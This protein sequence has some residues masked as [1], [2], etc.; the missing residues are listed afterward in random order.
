MGN[1]N[2]QTWN[3]KNAIA[4]LEEQD[5]VVLSSSEFTRFNNDW[6]KLQETIAN[7][8]NLTNNLPAETRGFS[9]ISNFFTKFTTIFDRWDN[10]FTTNGGEVFEG[11]ATHT[12]S[13][14][15]STGSRSFAGASSR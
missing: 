8:Q 10:W 12:S 7:L 9:K 1:E 14:R 3:K 15:V 2:N 4:F 6:N 11:G 13:S 5:C